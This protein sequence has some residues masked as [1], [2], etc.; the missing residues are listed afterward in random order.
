MSIWR[1]LAPAQRAMRAGNAG[2]AVSRRHRIRSR[3]HCLRKAADT[4]R[5]F[6]DCLRRLLRRG[7]SFSAAH[8]RIGCRNFGLPPPASLIAASVECVR[9]HPPACALLRFIPPFNIGAAARLQS[10]SPLPAPAGCSRCLLGLSRPLR[11]PTPARCLQLDV[12]PCAAAQGRRELLRTCCP[13]ARQWCAK[14]RRQ[15]L[16][17]S[18]LFSGRQRAVPPFVVAA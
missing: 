17:S 10:A 7:V 8:T 18:G 12:P 1:L 2:L 3:P 14:G 9:P 6:T 5:A 15:G 11:P 16:F 4:R 13:P